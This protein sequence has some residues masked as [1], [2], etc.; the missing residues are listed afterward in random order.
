MWSE[1]RAFI[2][3]GNVLDL[4]VAVV[5]GAAF[6]AIVNSLV[7][8]IIM[9]LVG[10]ILGGVDFTGLNL[11]VNN[12]VIAY[13]NFIQA[14]INFLIVAWVV[15]LVVKAIN[16]MSQLNKKPEVPA[17]PPAPSAEEKLLAEIRDLLAEQSAK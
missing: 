15:F 13:G 4:A 7:N 5:M 10:V 3:R 14:I 1:F 16:R 2:N 8:D 12:A 6:T 17:P 11:T 9:P